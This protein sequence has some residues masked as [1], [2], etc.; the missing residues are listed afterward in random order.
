MSEARDRQQER[1]PGALR[2]AAGWAWR[3]LVLLTLAGAVVF[4]V[5]RLHV[6]FVAMFV[7]LLSTA[8]L[9]PAARRLR[10][11]GVPRMLTTVIVM[12]GAVV[13]IGGLMY[14]VGRALFAQADEFAAAISVG[15]EKVRAW[16]IETFGTSLD[17]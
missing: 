17:D 6:L 16:M 7:A 14:L 13:A 4:V 12:V 1:V 10:A 5:V 8:L 2:T 15:I 3:I 11:A 9:A